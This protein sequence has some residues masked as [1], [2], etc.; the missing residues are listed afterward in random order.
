MAS[1]RAPRTG[2]ARAKTKTKSKSKS[3]SETKTR[4]QSKTKAKAKTTAR[5]DAKARSK[6]SA[7]A[8]ARPEVRRAE[9]GPGTRT[10]LEAGHASS[11]PPHVRAAPPRP[12]A[13]AVSGEGRLW[14]IVARVERAAHGALDASCDAFR[15]ELDALDDA[16]L[17]ATEAAFAAAMRRAYD[18]R[19]WS[20]AYLIHR[21]CGDDAFW[22]FRAG[23]IALGR[24]V[25]TAALADPDTLAAIVDL[26][27]RTLFEGFQYVPGAA[28]EARGLTSA[29]AGHSPGE[30]TGGPFFGDDEAALRR[31][32]PRLHARFGA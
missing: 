26:E 6:A 27:D 28:L 19:L 24:D 32:F 5:P 7:A 3:K 18:R 13:G 15:A 4:A 12:P 22:D 21:G 31:A 2:K 17:V 30:P 25:F 23:L 9:T 16:G 1:A 8:T 29:G 11:A 14:D 20:A 10:Q